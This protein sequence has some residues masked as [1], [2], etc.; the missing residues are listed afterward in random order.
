MSDGMRLDELVFDGGCRTCIFFDSLLPSTCK[1]NGEETDG[2][3]QCHSVRL[4]EMAW[5]C[6]Q[7]PFVDP[8][9][10]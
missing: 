5:L 10:S 4:R 3:E 1:L 6:Q 7:S 8:D 9:V 2:M